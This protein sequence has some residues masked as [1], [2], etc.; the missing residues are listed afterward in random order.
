MNLT[1]LSQSSP[2]PQVYRFLSFETKMAMDPEK[3]HQYEVDWT[4][5]TIL[6]VF[7]FA[8]RK[9][10]TYGE[11][12]GDY[13]LITVPNGEV[14]SDGSITYNNDAVDEEGKKVN[15]LLKVFAKPVGKHVASFS[16]SS[17]DEKHHTY[18]Y[19]RLQRDDVESHPNEPNQVIRYRAFQTYGYYEGQNKPADQILWQDVNI[20][21]VFD[22][23]RRKMHTYGEKEMDFDI[24]D[25]KV[26][27]MPSD[28]TKS[29]RYYVV[30]QDGEECQIG[31]FLFNN[32][33]DL[34]IGSVAIVLPAEKY[35]II[36]KVKNDE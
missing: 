8:K 17:Y 31:L 23:N 6:V 26:E 3:G 18:W 4:P 30:N 36:F 12:K 5:S 9:V 27:L 34:H 15:I 10:H 22:F 32:P 35:S 28:S 33:E 25:S 14:G 13:D 21:V 7:D 20:L 16:I 1:G 29:Y 11:K 24:Y 2:G 19:F